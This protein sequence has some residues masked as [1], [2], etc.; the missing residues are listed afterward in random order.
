M[1]QGKFMSEYSIDSL[2]SVSKSSHYTNS[3]FTQTD[4][5]N[6]ASIFIN[7]DKN[8]DGKVSAQEAEDYGFDFFEIQEDLDISKF[9][10]KISDL[11]QEDKNFLKK[12]YK[13]DER[14][15]YQTF[16]GIQP[17]ESITREK[18]D[19]NYRINL[20]NGKP[21]AGDL[22]F[23]KEILKKCKYDDKTF[24]NIENMPFD[25]QEAFELGKNPGLNVDLM[26]KM[27]Y[28]GKDVKVAISDAPLTKH[29]TIEENII[30]YH[31]VQDN[32]SNTN[33]HGP[34]VA[35]ILVGKD[36]GVATD[37]KA[38]FFASN[39]V[40]EHDNIDKLKKVLEYNKTAAVA[41][42]IRVYNLSA[43]LEVRNS[44]EIQKL[45][46]ELKENGCWVLDRTE[47]SENFGYLTKK[48]PTGSPND[49]DNHT[50]AYLSWNGEN[51]VY[52]NSGERTIASATGENNYRH[53]SAPCMSWAIP[54]MSGL[55]AAA[56]QANPNMT[57]EKFTKL[58]QLS[59]KEVQAEISPLA[60]E[61]SIAVEEI[62]Y[63]QALKENPNLTREEVKTYNA[64]QR[65]KLG[66]KFEQENPNI[67][68]DNYCQT[69]ATKRLREQGRLDADGNLTPPEFKK[70]KIADAKTLIEF[71]LVE[72]G[73]IDE[74]Y[75]ALK[76]IEPN[77]T[78]EKFNQR[79]SEIQDKLK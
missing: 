38:V 22:V 32:K 57:P 26:H 72:A 58:I 74:L 16:I 33:H 44:E 35:S 49:F 76:K 59:A 73:K 15:K 45:V 64:E 50:I 60:I 68:F 8:K 3:T 79:V 65:G 6:I 51:G 14:A 37:A 43:D 23:T 25:T 42:K 47:Y 55:Y 34:S 17:E 54:T 28:T 13:N 30:A 62:L 4:A 71:T 12:L 63:Q 66:Q 56:C 10:A 7:I 24:K 61:Q 70:I 53:D 11:T 78:Q 67:D 39:K 19:K 1:K 2:N 41:D 46:K 48:D 77:L 20:E 40:T 52:L 36:C 27:G 9:K 5:Q 69:L 18:C 31:G 29:S 21:L 75:V